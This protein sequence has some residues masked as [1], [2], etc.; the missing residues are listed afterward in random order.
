MSGPGRERIPSLDG[1]RAL[2]ISLVLAAHALGHN[3]PAFRDVQLVGVLGSL[4]VRIFFVISGFLITSLL[5]NETA[6]TGTVSLRQ[7]YLRRTLRIFPPFYVYTAFVALAAAM[8]WIALR[9]FDLLAAA[10]YTTNY[11]HDRSWYLGHIWSL[12]V[13]EQFYLLW[14]F[15]L[16]ALGA[17]RTAAAALATMV[18]APLLRI[19]LMIAAP[20][21]RVGIGETFPTVA[22]EIATG[23]LLACWRGRFEQVPQLTL[24]LRGRRFWLIP[25]V[26]LAA[27]LIPSAKVSC[28]IGETITNV[29]IALLIERVVRAPGIG[30]GRLLNTRPLVFVGTLSYSLYLWQQPFLYAESRLALHPVLLGIALV[31]A[32]ATLSHYVVERPA[33]RLRVRLERRW[34]GPRKAAAPAA[35]YPGPGAAA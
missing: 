4:G 20:S 18:A 23:C 3:G 28:F 33:Q 6:A 24:W 22:D 21:L 35:L 8:G 16:K 14:P 11:H 13:E 17:R 30:V 7:F 25:L 15:V 27:A 9:H 19:G 2:S 5:L 29:A 26:G 12:S 34:F 32:L 1:L 10:T 31:F